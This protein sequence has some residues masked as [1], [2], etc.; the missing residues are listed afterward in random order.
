[1]A[2]NVRSI[3]GTELYGRESYVRTAHSVL[4]RFAEHMSEE[5]GEEE[6]EVLGALI[7]LLRVLN[8]N[9]VHGREGATVVI[10]TAEE[11][12]AGMVRGSPLYEKVM[13]RAQEERFLVY[14]EESAT[15]RAPGSAAGGLG[16][17][18][19]THDALE[20]LRW[21]NALGE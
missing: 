9:Q 4:G 12:A 19:F 21:A 3:G 14:E 7:R 13:Q 1:V 17:Y 16:P 18:K 11:Q 15:A 2:Y 5:P 8:D 20:M 6:V 10:G